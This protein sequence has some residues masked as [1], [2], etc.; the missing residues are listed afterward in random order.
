MADDPIQRVPINQL[1][2]EDGAHELATSADMEPYLDFI[3]A[4]MQD[5]DPSPELE[6]IR[7]LPLENATFGG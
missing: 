5:R 4:M 2:Q 6:A 1:R 7:H 3:K